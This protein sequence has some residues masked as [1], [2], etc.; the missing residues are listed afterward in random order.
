MSEILE[1]KPLLLGSKRTGGAEMILPPK[2]API[3]VPFRLPPSLVA[4]MDE[5]ATRTNRS[6]NETAELLLRWAVERAKAELEAQEV[7][8]QAAPAAPSK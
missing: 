6:R 3:Q 2:E 5:L 1:L 4:E 7:V 8:P